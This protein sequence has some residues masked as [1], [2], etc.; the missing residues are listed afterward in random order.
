MR[1]KKILIIG[2]AGAGKSSLSRQLHQHT[3]LPLIHLDQLYW[4]PG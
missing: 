3:A 1:H 4:Q 2:C